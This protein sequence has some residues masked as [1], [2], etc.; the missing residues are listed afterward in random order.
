MERGKG[1]TC[2]E[3]EGDALASLACQ[4]VSCFV[5]EKCVSFMLTSTKVVSHIPED[6]VDVD[7]IVCC[8]S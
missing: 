5:V 4:L 7:A 3:N 8:F 6:V 2:V 1:S